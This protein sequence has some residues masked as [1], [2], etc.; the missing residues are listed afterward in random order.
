MP[1]DIRAPVDCRNPLKETSDIFGHIIEV[2]AY[3]DRNLECFVNQFCS[4]HS[5]ETNLLANS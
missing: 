2:S 3:R 1:D 4:S 5:T